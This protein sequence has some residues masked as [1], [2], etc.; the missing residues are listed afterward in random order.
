MEII[1]KEAPWEAVRP[2]VSPKT[3]NTGAARTGT[4]QEKEK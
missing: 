1:I 4:K 2:G 3:K